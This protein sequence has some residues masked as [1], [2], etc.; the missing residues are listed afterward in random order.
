[1]IADLEGRL[2]VRLLIRSTRQLS[3]TEA[4]M[5][6]YERALRAITETNEAEAA[7][8]GEAGLEGRLRVCTPVTFARLHLVPKLGTFLDA[9]PRIRLEL[10]MDDRPRDLVA[11]NYD[12][13]LRLGALTDSALIA[14]K[15]AQGERLVMASPTYLAKRGVPSAPEDLLRHNVT[16]A[17]KPWMQC[18]SKMR[19]SYRQVSQSS[20][21][22]VLRPHRLHVRP[23]EW[24]LSSLFIA[25]SWRRRAIFGGCG[26]HL[27]RWAFTES[28]EQSSNIVISW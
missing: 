4:G 21:L 5:A 10:V 20:S 8:Q 17:I 2:G 23:L 13:A 9:H 24:T 26:A 19:N 15:I 3:P 22:T 11:E 27:P 16:T 28:T 12:A 1:M 7:A 6:F 18:Y 25:G 14:R